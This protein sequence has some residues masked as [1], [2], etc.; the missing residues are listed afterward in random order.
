MKYYGYFFHC[1]SGLRLFFVIFFQ[2]HTGFQS[3][4]NLFEYNTN[5]IWNVLV[6]SFAWFLNVFS[7]FIEI[8]LS[9]SEPNGKQ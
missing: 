5:H 8:R 6:Y 4:V 9:H 1:Y 3:A 2:W 7:L